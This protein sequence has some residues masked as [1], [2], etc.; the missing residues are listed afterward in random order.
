MEIKITVKHN[1]QTVTITDK[2]EKFEY[3]D[4]LMALEKATTT[5]LDILPDE[6]L[7]TYIGVVDRVR[8]IQAEMQGRTEGDGKIDVEEG[9]AII[10]HTDGTV[11]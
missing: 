11:N 10:T 1:N 2:S 4:L 9:S 6:V 5:G 3:A 8:E 7:N